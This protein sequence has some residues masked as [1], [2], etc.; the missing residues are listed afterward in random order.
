MAAE[1]QDAPYLQNGLRGGRILVVEGY[2]FQRNKTRGNK[3]FWRCSRRECRVFIQ[4]NLFDVAAEA[5]VIHLRNAVPAH[6]HAPDTDLIQ[7]SV[8]RDRCRAVITEDPTLAVKRVYNRVSREYRR[9]GHRFV[10]PEFT[11]VE[12]LLRRMRQNV[13][14][15]IPQAIADVEIRGPWATTWQGHP[16][17]SH[18]DNEWEYAIFATERNYQR[19]A[20]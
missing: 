16:F 12:K 20:R 7:E 4:T 3:I 9:Q 5:P 19:L 1:Q 11:R 15:G 6:N 14:P 13:F 2:R 17:L 18:V 8:F 10:L